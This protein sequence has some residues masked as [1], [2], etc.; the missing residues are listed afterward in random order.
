MSTQKGM[1]GS[2]SDAVVALISTIT[3]SA[4]AI[5]RLANAADSLAAVAEAKAMRFGQLIEIKDEMIYNEAK[6]ALDAQVDALAKTKAA[7]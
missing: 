6:S 7:K 4:T 3:T 1:I 5:N 2:A